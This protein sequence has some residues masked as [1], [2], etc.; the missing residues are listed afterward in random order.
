MT[1]RVLYVAHPL[2]PSESDLTAQP[3]YLTERGRNEYE[4]DHTIALTH[5]QRVKHALDANLQRA[6]RW[7]A[8]LRRSFPQDTFIAPW[9]ATVMSLHGD[10]SPELREA[11][12][13]DDCAVVERCDGIV[14]C[15]SR[16]SSGMRREMAHGGHRVGLLRPGEPWPVFDLT[17][18]QYKAP[19]PDVDT[20]G[21]TLEEYIHEV[22]P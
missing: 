5:G 1:R 10:D 3:W 6:M 9:I 15:G 12:L 2:S 16:I 20:L 18:L 14:L 13:V 22:T 8:W 17:V 11:G 7:L 19:P 4:L 21:M